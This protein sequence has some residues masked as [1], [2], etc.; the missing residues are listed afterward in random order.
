HMAWDDDT[1]VIADIRNPSTRQQAY[2][3][4]R[5]VLAGYATSEQRVL[6]GFDFAYGYPQGFARAVVPQGSQPWRD[7]WAYLH[8]VIQDD[9]RNR[10]NRFEVGSRL[11]AQLTGGA[12]PFWGCPKNEQTAQL[13]MRKPRG[14]G[15]DI[16][17]EFRLVEQANHAHSVWKLSYPGAVGS[18]VLMGL[19][20]LY[21]L[22]T[23]PDL[24][25]VSKVWPFDTGLKILGEADLA[26]VHILHAEIYPS[27]VPV[28]PRDGEI[29]DELQ[30]RA[31][32]QYIADQDYQGCLARLF[33]GRRPLSDDE[34]V[35]V[36]TEEG[37]ILGI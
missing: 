26:G 13:S 32:A 1:L 3:Q 4:I 20:Y 23:E 27:L 30:V 7:V 10:N 31:L 17:S 2:D 12:A 9:Q 37:W 25:Y 8:G 21:A 28:T 16:F 22:I 33:A 36:E 19:P 15:A 11:N 34:R 6:V 35:T 29:K 14:T 5:M 24:Q 18:Q